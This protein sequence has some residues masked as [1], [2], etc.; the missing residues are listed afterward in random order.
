MRASRRTCRIAC[1]T[2]TQAHGKPPPRRSKAG[3]SIGKLVTTTRQHQFFPDVVLAKEMAE[4]LANLVNVTGL[5]HLEMDGFDANDGHFQYTRKV[6]METL[7][8]GLENKNIL[9]GT[10]ICCPTTGIGSG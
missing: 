3:E 2:V 9:H 1:S 7:F 4:N 5:S 8:D 10:A 6:F